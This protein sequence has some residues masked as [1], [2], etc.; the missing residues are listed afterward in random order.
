MVL[1]I[2]YD[3]TYGEIKPFCLQ[4]RRCIARSCHIIILKKAIPLKVFIKMFIILYYLFYGINL[5][6]YRDLYDMSC[7]DLNHK[8]LKK[9]LFDWDGEPEV[10]KKLQRYI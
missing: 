2:V 4:Q 7:M 1:G 9:L 8:D 3:S 10:S 5:I 6:R